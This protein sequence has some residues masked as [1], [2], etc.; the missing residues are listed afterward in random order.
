VVTPNT[1]YGVETPVV[2]RVRADAQRNRARLLAVAEDVF[3]TYGVGASTEDIARAAGVGIG[4]LFRHFPTKEALLEAVF[5]ER[6][7]QLADQ[8]DELAAAAEPGAAFFRFFSEVV[9]QARSKSAIGDALADA[10]INLENTAAEVKH[11][12]RSALERL[13]ERAQQ[14]GEIRSDVSTAELLALLIGASRAVEQL[15]GNDELEARTVR[16]ILDGLRV[17]QPDTRPA[18]RPRRIRRRDH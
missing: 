18:P 2:K 8:A 12:L 11:H 13:L 5:V 7:R 1:E 17:Q 9:Q 10:G 6:L 4:T 16:V 3:A 14:A 15:G